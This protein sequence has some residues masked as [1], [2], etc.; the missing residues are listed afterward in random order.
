METAS[1]L[2]AG[3]VTRLTS[4]VVIIFHSQ[5]TVSDSVIS[6]IVALLFEVYEY[7]VRCIVR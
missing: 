6:I 5:E 2:R 3:N 1:L 4:P 7:Y